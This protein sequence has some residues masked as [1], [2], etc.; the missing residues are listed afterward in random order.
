MC[1]KIKQLSM[2]AARLDEM[3][4]ATVEAVKNIKNVAGLINRS[5]VHG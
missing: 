1:R 4:L 3:T 2:K 5:W